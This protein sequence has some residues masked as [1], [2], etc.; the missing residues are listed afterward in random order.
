[1][2][3]DDE[4]REVAQ[5]LRTVARDCKPRWT[6]SMADVGDAT[7]QVYRCSKC[8]EEYCMSDIKPYPWSFCPMCGAEV[9]N[10]YR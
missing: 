8:G 1:M 7:E 5:E 6:C 2:I 3:T 9:I 4:R 10:D